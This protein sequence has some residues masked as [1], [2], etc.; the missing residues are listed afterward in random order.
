YLSSKTTVEF[1]T[2]TIRKDNYKNLALT[3]NY[4]E[5]LYIATSLSND[6]TT[7][8]NK[9]SIKMNDNSKEKAENP[10]KKNSPEPE[11]QEA[12]I[13]EQNVSMVEAE[14]SSD[15]STIQPKVDEEVVKTGNS[16]GPYTA[17]TI[18]TNKENIP[19]GSS[20]A[21]TEKDERGFTEVSYKKKAKNKKLKEIKKDLK[22]AEEALDWD[23]QKVQCQ[24]IFRAC[25]PPTNPETCI[26]KIHK[27]ITELNNKMAKNPQL[28]DLKDG[29]KSTKYFFEQYKS[30]SSREA[31][32]LVRDPTKP[33]VVDHLEILYYTRNKFEALYQAELIDENAVKALM[34]DLPSEILDTIDKLPNYKAPGAYSIMYEFYKAFQDE[35]VPVLRKSEDLENISNWRPISL[36][37]TDAKIFMKIIADRLNNICKNIIGEQQAGFVKDRSIVDVAM[38]IIS[39][40]RSQENQDDTAWL[41]FLDQKKAF[42]RVNHSYLLQV[43]EKMNFSP[44]FVELVKSLFD[45]LV[46]HITDAVL[47]STPFKINKGVRQE[48]PLSPLLYVIAFEPFLRTLKRRISRAPTGLTKFQLMAYVDDLTVG[49]AAAN[50]AVNKEKS[51]LFPLTKEALQTALPGEEHFDKLGESGTIRIL[52]YEVNKE[53]QLSKDFWNNVTTKMKKLIEM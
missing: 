34:E 28:D 40:M 51:K 25:K 36:V 33:T 5:N 48:D 1:I 15:T 49:L 6:R 18:T 52:G 39:M 4:H 29:E 13:F 23:F 32:N 22:E 47:L 19:L 11:E 20:N 35:V 3:D 41:L 26:Q 44:I 9:A 30:K 14:P 21:N 31:T 7:R 10:Y 37:N 8:L 43:L 45:Y 53:C 38:D 46:A 24:S 16:T 17:L 50:A 27:R 2:N 12:T 42:D